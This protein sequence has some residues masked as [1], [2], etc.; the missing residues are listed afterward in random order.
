[1]MTIPCIDL[2]A[3]GE[4]DDYTV[5]KAYC[6]ELPLTPDVNQLGLTVHGM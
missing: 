4:H 2:D 3:T 6:P 1:M 5:C